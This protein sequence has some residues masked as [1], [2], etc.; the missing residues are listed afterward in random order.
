MRIIAH[1]GVS[2]LAPENTMAA[3]SKCLDLGITW[4]EFD[5]QMI[6]DG[7]LVVIH[8]DSLDRTT[9][10]TGAVAEKTF[11]QLRGVDAGAWFGDVYRMERI[12]E[13]SSVVEL[14]NSTTLAANLEVKPVGSAEQRD[15]VV[16]AVAKVAGKVTD[17]KKLLISSFDEG[18]LANLSGFRTAYLVDRAALKAD[19]PGRVNRAVELGCRAI[20]PEVAGF[21]ESGLAAMQSAGLEVNVW[22]VDDLAEGKKLAEWGVDGLITNRPQDFTELL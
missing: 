2:S 16:E 7:S 18:V 11:A 22:T 20:H 21:D 6:A 14:L 9:N 13:L 1:R 8:D 17:Q 4:F 3:F 15:A 5:V 10:A 19:L 12:P